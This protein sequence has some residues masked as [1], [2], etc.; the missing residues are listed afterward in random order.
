[1]PCHPDRAFFYQG[2]QQ[3]WWADTVKKLYQTGAELTEVLDHAGDGCHV[4]FIMKDISTVRYKPERLWEW[5][6]IAMEVCEEAYH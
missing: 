3:T 4:E 5:A 1:M 6:E 2:Q